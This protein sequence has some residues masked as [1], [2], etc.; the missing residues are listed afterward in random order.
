MVTY[1]L[2]VAGT[3][4]EKQWRQISAIF[5]ERWLAGNAARKAKAKL[6]EG[7][8]NYY[9]IRRHRVGNALL[10]LI[11]RSLSDG[12]IT[13]TKAGKVLGVKP[14]SVGPLLATTSTPWAA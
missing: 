10:S 2:F 5:R 4:S 8:P 12:T 11:S 9:V 14:R 7:G 6:S 1:R 3:I 13:P